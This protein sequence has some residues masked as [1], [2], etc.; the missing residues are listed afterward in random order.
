MEAYDSGAGHGTLRD[1]SRRWWFHCTAIA[2]G[3]REIADGAEVRFSVRPGRRGLWEAA[4][5]EA[6]EPQPA[7]GRLD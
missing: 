6:I 4:C 3:S 7:G 5:I 2:D 1:G